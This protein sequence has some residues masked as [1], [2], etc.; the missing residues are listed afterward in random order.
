M[1]CT[2]FKIC[3]SYC[4][5]S[6]LFNFTKK[7]I[8]FKVCFVPSYF[9]DFALLIPWLFVTMISII[10]RIVIAI[11]F[12]LRFSIDSCSQLSILRFWLSSYP[13]VIRKLVNLIYYLLKLCLCLRRALWNT[14]NRWPKTWQNNQKLKLVF[15][16]DI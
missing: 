1:V 10:E 9:Y 4:A 8:S 11:L 5:K 16:I 7:A 6:S 3:W 15:L 13:L 14:W 2:K 12:M